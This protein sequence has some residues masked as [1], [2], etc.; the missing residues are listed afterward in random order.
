[1]Q[2]QSAMPFNQLRHSLAAGSIESAFSFGSGD[3]RAGRLV[4]MSALEILIEDRV[5]EEFGERG[6]LSADRRVALK[7][8]YSSSRSVL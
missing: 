6:S 8:S 5:I 4:A 2:V 3:N 1:M 7:N